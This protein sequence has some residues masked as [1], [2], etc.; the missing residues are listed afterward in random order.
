MLLSRVLVEKQGFVV[1][2]FGLSQFLMGIRKSLI[3]IREPV[4]WVLVE[5]SGVPRGFGCAFLEERKK[6]Y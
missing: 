2:P 5:A 3:G 4:V 6:S 1:K